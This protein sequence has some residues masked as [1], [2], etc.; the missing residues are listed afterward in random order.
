MLQTVA[1]AYG[2]PVPEEARALRELARRLTQAEPNRAGPGGRLAAGRV[3]S[4]QVTREILGVL[5]HDDLP[6][7]NEVFALSPRT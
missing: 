2:A 6:H 7:L 3:P 4:D 1:G 5:A